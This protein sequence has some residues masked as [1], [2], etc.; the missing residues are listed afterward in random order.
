MF[1]DTLETRGHHNNNSS[2]ETLIRFITR[3]KKP[4]AGEHYFFVLFIFSMIPYS[5]HL[6]IKSLVPNHV[7]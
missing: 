6:L 7:I 4:E 3:A 2:E 1:L 5:S